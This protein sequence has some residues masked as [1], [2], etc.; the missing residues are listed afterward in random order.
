[1]RHRLTLDPAGGIR[2]VSAALS[3]AFEPSRAFSPDALARR[4]EISEKATS[5]NQPYTPLDIV[6][7]PGIELPEGTSQETVEHLLNLYFLWEL[8][9]H[10]VISRP[11]FLRDMAAG[12]GPYFSSMLLNVSLTR[13]LYARACANSSGSR[14]WHLRAR[15]PIVPSK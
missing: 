5:A 10:P 12:R 14:Y 8:P 9:L 3:L 13:T 7:G 15:F 1:M 2:A 11:A 6:L 4:P